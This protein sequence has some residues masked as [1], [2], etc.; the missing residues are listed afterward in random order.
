MLEQRPFA[1]VISE[2]PSFQQAFE[3]LLTRAPGPVFPRARALY[4]QKYP[5]EGEPQGD[6]RTFLLEE[7]IQ[8]SPVGALRIR[9]LAMAIVAW[10]QPRFDAA[11][12]AT[13]LQQRWG[14]RP[15]D[16]QEVEGAS[17]FRDSGAYGRFSS[18]AVY[19]RA[20]PTSLISSSADPGPP[21]ADPG[22]GA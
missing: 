19:E 3:R 18:L 5:L 9:A 17:W 12:A 11:A 7:D 20:A 21:A 13:Y 15:H 10:G 1:T 16:L 8:E 4:L 22:S 14:L 6:F 2:P